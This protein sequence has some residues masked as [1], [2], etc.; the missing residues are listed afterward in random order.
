MSRELELP[1]SYKLILRGARLCVALI[2]I[3]GLTLIYSSFKLFSLGAAAALLTLGEGM[4]YIVG[5]FVLLGVL[6]SF[7]E[8]AIAQL[9]T[10]NEMVKLTAEL[11]KNKT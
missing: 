7:M 8:S 4:F 9:E 5:S 10:R 1:N 3:F 6:H 2:C 11:A